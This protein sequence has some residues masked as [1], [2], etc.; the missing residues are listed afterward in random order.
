MIVA[1]GQQFRPSLHSPSH[2]AIARQILSPSTPSLLPRPPPPTLLLLVTRLHLAFD[3]GDAGPGY[4]A[5][6]RLVDAVASASDAAS[7]GIGTADGATTTSV[8][9]TP[10]PCVAAFEDVCAH[11]LTRLS[12]IPSDVGSIASSAWH[13]VFDV[14]MRDVAVGD[15]E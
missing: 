6:R 13:F 15:S 4:T 10:L 3:M 5:T 9:T 7:V 2:Q 14:G 11:A 1:Y 12:N 8:T